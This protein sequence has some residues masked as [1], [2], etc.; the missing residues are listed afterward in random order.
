M[1]SS[2]RNRNWRAGRKG[3]RKKRDSANSGQLGL[4][5]VLLLLA[6]VLVWVMWPRPVT[7]V[8]LF[9]VGN[10]PA[11]Q[12]DDEADLP[13]IQ[14]AT[15]DNAAVS[16]TFETLAERFSYIVQGRWVSPGDFKSLPAEQ[17]PGPKSV[18]VVFLHAHPNSVSEGSPPRLTFDFCVQG[19]KLSFEE[20]VKK[21]TA[22]GCRDVLLLLE[23]SQ[24]LPELLPGR[25]SLDSVALIE[26]EL[27]HVEG[28]Y[29]DL[30]LQV[31]TSTAAR[32]SS[33]PYVE[34]LPE[35]SDLYK[36]GYGPQIMTRSLFA[37]EVNQVLRQG[38][39]RT[40][41]ELIAQVTRQ[42]ETASKEFSPSAQQTPQLLSVGKQL[43]QAIRLFHDNYKLASTIAEPEE[44]SVPEEAASNGNDAPSP[45]APLPP[46]ELLK[47]FRQQVAES[48]GP[49]GLSDLTLQDWFELQRLTERAEAFLALGDR[50]QFRRTL[51]RGDRRLRE[52]AAPA[53]RDGS[54]EGSERWRQWIVP[55]DLETA[56][57]ADMFDDV[58]AEANTES[59]SRSPKLVEK[60]R[61][62][63]E[64]E[65]LLSAF[66]ARLQVLEE[67][68]NDPSPEALERRQ[69]WLTDARKLFTERLSRKSG[70]RET[71][72]PQQFL[73]ATDLLQNARFDWTAAHFD[74][75][76]LL[77]RVRTEA[78]QLAWGFDAA[79]A[80]TLD[81]AAHLQI[82][83]KLREVL[84]R[85][86]AAERWFLIG[87]PAVV[88]MEQEAGLAE[89]TLKEIRDSLREARRRSTLQGRTRQAILT[90]LEEFALQQEQ[91]TLS[92]N[93]IQS[94]SERT[95]DQL[96]EFDSQY[97]PRASFSQETLVQR[98]SDWLELTQ[99]FPLAP[100]P[101]QL[102]KFENLLRTLVAESSSSLNSEPATPGGVLGEQVDF[103]RWLRHSQQG[104]WLSFWSI[105][106]LQ[107]IDSPQANIRPLMESWKRYLELWSNSEAQP[108]EIIGRRLELE[109]QL[110]QA[111]RE[112]GSS[113][114]YPREPID[115][116][117]VQQ[118]VRED[119]ERHARTAGE[120]Y[121]VR[122]GQLFPGAERTSVSRGL[123]ERLQEL[124]IR[125]GVSQLELE[126]A[127]GTNLMFYP[128]KVQIDDSR[129]EQLHGWQ[130][131]AW[132]GPQQPIRI[133]TKDDFS[134]E[135]RPILVT[136]DSEGIVQEY[137]VPEI[138]EQFQVQGW[139]V[140]FSSGTVLMRANDIAEG[141]KQ[142]LLPPVTGAEPLP[143]HVE[144]VSPQNT[145]TASV[146]VKLMLL[147]EVGNPTRALWPEF[148][149]V[150]L[151]PQTRRA[152][153]P[154]LAPPVE[155]ASQPPPAATPAAIDL[156]RGLAF[157]VKPVDA[158]A[159]DQAAMIRVRMTYVDPLEDYLELGQPEFDLERQLLTL[160]VRRRP[161]IAPERFPPEA[162]GVEMHF[163]PRLDG[164][165]RDPAPK[166]PEVSPA[167]QIF[168]TRFD[169]GIDEV[170]RQQERGDS[171]TE[172]AFSDG[173][174]MEFSLSVL[175]MQDAVRWRLGRSLNIERI[176][177]RLGRGI[178]LPGSDAELRIGSQLVNPEDDGVLSQ[179]YEGML[180]LTKNWD[181]SLLHLPIELHGYKGRNDSPNLLQLSLRA[182]NANR[183]VEIAR[184][185]GISDAYERQV[186]VNPGE[187]G[188][189]NFTIASQRF[190]QP[191]LNYKDRYNL[192]EGRHRFQVRL[193][194][195]GTAQELVTAET[196]FIF[197]D[198][199]PRIIWDQDNL[200][201]SLVTTPYHGRIS[202]EDLQ[203]DVHG[204]WVGFDPEALKPVNL[205]RGKSQGRS[206]IDALPFTIE[207]D[208]YPMIPV[209]EGRDVRKTAKLLIRAVNGVGL[210]QIV[211]REIV[212]IQPAPKMEDSSTPP[213][214]K[215]IIMVTSTADHEVKLEGEGGEF[216]KDRFKRTTEFNNVPA[217]KY[218][219]SWKN[220]AYD[221]RYKEK[222]VTVQFAKQGETATLN[223]P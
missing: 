94:L 196:T 8:H 50:Q 33:L 179:Y 185:Q 29:P 36:A 113:P 12:P 17:L 109:Q 28:A 1:A 101:Q 120:R 199:P 57:R 14:I 98:G 168:E 75:F 210:E 144:L 34:N 97:F 87:A 58:I 136:L 16:E 43:Q 212:L 140:R 171:A 184:H 122:L 220:L 127:V 3:D 173:Q 124:R 206:R 190:S 219:L 156:S 61:E 139:D 135:A 88:M 105:R 99:P 66:L 164:L 69:T 159:G 32:R 172:D 60:F 24:G 129:F 9:V 103:S 148:R 26:A 85:A 53:M 133:R 112:S 114:L 157:L 30:R 189:W 91:Q 180:V 79:G 42:V 170:I 84:R 216:A 4:W 165:R 211:E 202:V 21:L 104:I 162:I 155:G 54:S 195:E 131:G 152:T 163:S 183:P 70:W 192:P 130:K 19:M 154:L 67:D 95:I 5:A 46:L 38:T 150:Q 177:S 142:L 118:I 65:A 41:P 74:V 20:L 158:A 174:G 204:V 83:A 62:S 146:L 10:G 49:Q 71:E 80:R 217:G 82:S 203:T 96:L 123:S 59:D 197:E 77:I 2:S 132:Y 100:T 175:G 166:N 143:V 35:A 107:A 213:K 134:G 153:L 39:A 93:E 89:S 106:A 11:N 215:V 44:D 51:D 37:E 182:E 187:G 169:A 18:A 86:T 200:K 218:T 76:I 207:R 126:A 116:E 128:D 102:T 141:E 208:D 78:L 119:L 198:S 25:L 13:W 40:L 214:G 111:W 63:S 209:E 108:S 7:Q 167:G 90:R 160:S 117:Q 55:V 145:F 23:L 193:L 92:A 138:R 15:A 191:G 223:I 81:R 201:Q 151:D 22:N 205:L 31:L 161:V 176:G 178:G 149:E 137:A 64:R 27:K 45:E 121:A 222:P 147:D 73:L 125:E 6:G 48:T 52:L 221:T 194:D 186:Q 56:G 72:W 115:T 47:Q 188:G 181:K 110:R 68:L